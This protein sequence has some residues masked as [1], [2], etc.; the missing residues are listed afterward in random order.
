MNRIEYRNARRLIRDN[1]RYALRWLPAEQRDALDHLMFNI[2][3]STDQL[4]E[5]ADIIAHCQREGAYCTPRH[6]ASRDVLSR[7]ADRHITAHYRDRAASGAAASLRWRAD[8]PI[9]LRRA[10]IE[11]VWFCEEADGNTPRRPPKRV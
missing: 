10:L 9:P 3:D 11:P 6:T 8:Q 2:Q 1:G 7:F 5:R 4:A